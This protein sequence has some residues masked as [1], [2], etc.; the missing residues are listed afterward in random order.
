[1]KPVNHFKTIRSMTLIG[2]LLF[3]LMFILF[4]LGLIQPM[5]RVVAS[6]MRD[7]HTP[8][9]DRLVIG[10][11]RLGSPPALLFYTLIT[12]LFTLKEAGW[13]YLGTFITAVW[14]TALATTLIKELIARERPLERLVEISSHSFPSWHSSTSAALAVVLWAWLSPKYGRRAMLIFLWPFAIGLSRILLNA[15]WTSDVLAGWGLGLA[16][17]GMVLMLF[18]HLMETEKSD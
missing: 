7:L 8:L 10:L 13:R 5:D 9:F 14:G 11:T 16:V 12:A 17:S 18:R 1:M 15:H 6:W 3:S 4:Q 2:A